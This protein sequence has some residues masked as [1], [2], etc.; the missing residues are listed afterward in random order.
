M[1]TD[2][3]VWERYLDAPAR[4]YLG[5]S[6][7]V[8][9]GEGD[10]PGLQYDENLRSMWYCLTSRRID[11][12]GHLADGYELIEVKMDA[13]IIAVGQCVGYPILWRET[14]PG[15]PLRGMRLVCASLSADMRT[16][17]EGCGVM[18]SVV[19]I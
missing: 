3:P 1:K 17:L 4:E 7:D 15:L 9:V 2:I 14:F 12:V 5:Y 16:M 10:D 8:K 11:V 19:Q 6:Y 13:G 18:V